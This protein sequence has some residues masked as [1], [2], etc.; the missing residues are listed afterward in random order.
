MKTAFTTG[1]ILTYFD[2]TRQTKLEK[3]AS[4]FALGAVLSPFCED[5]KWPPVVFHNRKFAPAE[6]NYNIYD[7]EMTA[8][9]AAFKE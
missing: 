2:E 4:D 3:D 9:V 6:V 8:I 5:E 1:P 7:K